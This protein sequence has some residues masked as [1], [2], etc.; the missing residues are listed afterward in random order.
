MVYAILILLY[1]VITT[2]IIYDRLVYFRS[3]KHGNYE[4]T[5]GFILKSDHLENN[6]INY[7]SIDYIFY[8]NGRAFIGHKYIFPRINYEYNRDEMNEFIKRYPVNKEVTVYY[9]KRV[10]FTTG[11]YGNMYDSYLEIDSIELIRKCD[12]YYDLFLINTYLVL[13]LLGLTIISRLFP[14]I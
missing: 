9:K 7:P 1:Y 11:I 12:F 2:K 8:V 10:D 4:T 6:E 13:I 3:G 5:K 14:L